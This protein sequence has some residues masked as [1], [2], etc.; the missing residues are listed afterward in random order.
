MKQMAINDGLNILLLILEQLMFLL[1]NFGKFY[2]K[3]ILIIYKKLN[4]RYMPR[5]VLMF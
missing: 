2:F 1:E 3:S 5:T 4:T